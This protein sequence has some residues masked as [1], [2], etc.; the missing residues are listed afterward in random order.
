MSNL[1]DNSITIYEAINN[2]KDGKYVMPAFQRQYVW[3]MEQIENLWDSILL[4][5]PI[6]TF[7]FWHIDDSNVTWDTYFCTFLQ[8][9]TFNSRKQ[10]NDVNYSL[11]SVNV[12]NT[13]TA[14]LDGQ[15]RLTSL[16]LSLYGNSFIRPSHARKSN[17]CKI[18]TKLLIE[19]DKNKLDIDEDEY[20]SKKFGI[21]F[22]D[23]VGNITLTQ[24]DIK[25]IFDEK[26]Q[27]DET[28]EQ[29]IEDAI[30]NVPPDSKDY[31]KNILNK[32]YNK[33]F[34]EP[35]IRYVEINDMKQDDALEMFIRFNS[36]GKALR[37]QEITM[38]ILE[39]YWP[40]AKVEFGKILIDDY[41]NFS[42]DFIIRSALMLYGDVKKTVINKQVA[43]DLKNNWIEFKMALHNMKDLFDK[44]NIDLT[45]FA[46]RYTE[47]IPIVYYIY[48]N[49]DYEKDMLAIR[50]YI[51][52][53]V[54]FTY[55]RSG[56]T[57][58]KLHQLKN[59]I[60]DYNMEFSIEMLD[61]ISK[62]RVTDGKIEDILNLEKGSNDVT[63]V[64]YYLGLD[65]IN[66]N[67]KYEQD[68]LHPENRF[69]SSKPFNVSSEDWKRWR[70]MRNRLPNLHLL[71]GRTNASKSDMRLID[72]CNDMN[73][74][75]KQAFYKEAMIPDGVSL[76][77]EDFEKF[78]EARKQLLKEKIR[79]LLEP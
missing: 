33:I 53:A 63:E 1:I 79:K 43:D 73:D 27:N 78:Y 6:S 38:S 12:K 71:E 20:N 51:I 49:P 68:H 69:N 46:N 58:G 3:S 70:S 67:F 37:K 24:F 74:A 35:I 25:N 60:N 40:S 56:G 47:L 45:R 55:F 7:L 22:T 23:K 17:G 50:T 65:W 39:A 64:L 57:P 14:I 72:Y 52:R 31:A 77:F 44:M 30:S 41:K 11:T 5:Y 62:F 13:D 61:Q 16:F 66:K 48:Y 36:G 26:F 32:L 8:E 21:K 19:L 9:A 54:F 34:V 10:A 59:Y 18:V 28:R 15:Q 42:T 75:Q 2:I 76:E 4:D 29:A